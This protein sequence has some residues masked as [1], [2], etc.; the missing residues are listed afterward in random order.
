MDKPSTN[1]TPH[2]PRWADRLL[3][4]LTPTEL[5]EE[6][7]GDLHEQFAQRIDQVGPFWARWWY[8]L[9]ALKVIR[10]Y[11]LRRRVARLTHRVTGFFTKQSGNDY[12]SFIPEHQSSPLINP[13]MLRS[14]LKIAIRNLAKNRVYSFINIGGLAMGMVVAMLNGLWVWDELSFNTYHKNYDRIAQVRELGRVDGKRYSNATLPYPLAT[15]LKANYADYF[16][17]ILVAREAEDYILATDETKISQK[18]QFIASGGPDMLSL[19][20]LKGSWAGLSD[21]H[22]ILLSASTAKAIFGTTDPL[23]K[24][25]KINATM[26]AKVTGIYE[27]LPHNSEF[28]EVNFFCPVRFVDFGQSLGKRAAMEQLVSLDLCTASAANRYEPGFGCH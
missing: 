2:P 17:H 12:P 6:L 3:C 10:P 20:M 19:H 22:S 7:Q 1:P 24:P 23:N 25:V 11:Y 5:L 16:K 13:I 28:H 14:Y 8:G 26:D 9:E 15:E 27:D 4:W 18:G 21:P